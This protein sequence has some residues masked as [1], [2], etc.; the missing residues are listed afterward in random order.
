MPHMDKDAL[1]QFEKISK[2]NIVLTAVENLVFFLFGKW[3][4]TVFIGSLWGLFLT[5]LFFYQICVSIPKALRMEDPDLASKHVRTTQIERLFILGLGIVAAMKLDFI[6]P[7]AALIPLI[8]TRISIM[9]AN[10]KGEEET[11]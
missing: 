1:K 2:I 3:D 8:F 6:N 10:F 7:W 5:S 4:I 11:E 9:I